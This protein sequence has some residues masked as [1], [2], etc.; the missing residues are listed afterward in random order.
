[1]HRRL[2][3]ILNPRENSG[4]NVVDLDLIS[5]FQEVLMDIEIEG[6]EFTWTNKRKGADLIEEKLNKAFVNNMQRDQ[7]PIILNMLVSQQQ[8]CDQRRRQ[9]RYRFEQM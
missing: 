4:G 1:M 2:S 6:Y 9:K 8:R 3:Q 7:Y 5:Q